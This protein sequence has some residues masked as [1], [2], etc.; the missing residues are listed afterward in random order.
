M[1][2]TCW[3]R[4]RRPTSKHHYWTLMLYKTLFKSFNNKITTMENKRQRTNT[5][6]KKKIGN[7]ILVW[8]SLLDTKMENCKEQYKKKEKIIQI[9]C[10]RTAIHVDNAWHIPLRK[11]TI[12]SWCLIK[13]CSNHSRTI[14]QQRKN[15][16]QR[17]QIPKRK[18]K[19]GNN[20]LVWYSLLDT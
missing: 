2:L 18:K 15:K 17:T 10:L 9:E 14:I 7:N 1:F 6:R 5:K 12:E 3:S 11:I 16:R 19:I 8:N 4:V 20:I 13:R